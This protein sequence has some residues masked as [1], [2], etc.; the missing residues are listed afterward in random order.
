MLF[1]SSVPDTEFFLYHLQDKLTSGDKSM[2]LS[3]FKLSRLF[4][5]LLSSESSSCWGSYGAQHSKGKDIT[6]LN[7][8]ELIAY[9]DAHENG[10]TNIR[11]KKDEIPK[12]MKKHEQVLE[13]KNKHLMHL[14]EQS[15][16]AAMGD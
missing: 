4:F 3:T 8:E 13:E 6:S 11:E 14:V 12:I 2:D 15:E 16:M 1:P 5:S 7:Y 9:E 10:I